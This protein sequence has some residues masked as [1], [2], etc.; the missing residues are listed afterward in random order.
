MK[1]EKSRKTLT[2]EQEICS[3]AQEKKEKIKM[4]DQ[5]HE[6]YQD[7]HNNEIEDDDDDDDENDRDDLNDVDQ[8]DD[9]SDDEKIRKKMMKYSKKCYVD[10]LLKIWRSTLEGEGSSISNSETGSY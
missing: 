4:V 6:N 7:D 1:L 8:N 3:F 10:S 9:Q 2:N 5:N